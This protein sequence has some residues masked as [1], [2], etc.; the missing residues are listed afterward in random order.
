M[1]FHEFCESET[2]IAR[3]A[4]LSLLVWKK[5][6]RDNTSDQPERMK[7]DVVYIQSMMMVSWSLLADVW[8]HC[9]EVLSFLIFFSP[10][11]QSLG[12]RM[13]CN[14]WSSLECWRTF[15]VMW[16]CCSAILQQL[17]SW[18]FFSGVLKSYSPNVSKCGSEWERPGSL[19]VNVH[20]IRYLYIFSSLVNGFE[21][22]RSARQNDQFN[23]A[24]LLTQTHWHMG[25]SLKTILLMWLLNRG[26]RCNMCPTTTAFRQET[27]RHRSYTSEPCNS[28]SY[29][30]ASP[31]KRRY[32]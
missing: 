27:N 21:K 20:N 3:D 9:R 26:C 4:Q 14:V 32:K 5:K 11:W 16:W 8:P 2:F 7:H 22:K 15:L 12:K 6:T 17:D 24:M 25:I 13:P 1:S 31:P 29:T 18:C 19:G 23:I 30:N 28:A 10:M